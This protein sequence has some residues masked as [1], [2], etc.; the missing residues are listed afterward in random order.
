LLIAKSKAKPEVANRLMR[1]SWR[2]GTFIMAT[3]GQ[4]VY[5]PNA[6]V[7]MGHVLPPSAEQTK[8]IVLC[9]QIRIFASIYPWIWHNQKEI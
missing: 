1:F 7:N 4:T 8:M 9:Q 3:E 6:L 2:K 5:F